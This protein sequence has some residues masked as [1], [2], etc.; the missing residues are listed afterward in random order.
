MQQRDFDTIYYLNVYP[1]A[2]KIDSNENASVYYDLLGKIMD[3]LNLPLKL[4]EFKDRSP[5]SLI[6][7]RAGAFEKV[8]FSGDL[9]IKATSAIVRP[10]G[11]DMITVRINGHDSK[12]DNVSE[13]IPINSSSVS[14]HANKGI[15]F[16]GGS[17]FYS[18]ISLDQPV[19]TFDGQPVRLMLKNS[20]GNQTSE[21]TASNVE[22]SL[23]KAD[24]LI[25]E[26]QIDSTGRTD[27]YKFAGYGELF[28]AIGGGGLGPNLVVTGKTSFQVDYSD[29][30]TI[31]N[32]L[33]MDGKIDRSDPFYGYDELGSLINL[34]SEYFVVFPIVGVIVYFLS[35]YKIIPSRE[36]T[37]FKL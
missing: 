19:I 2:Q 37:W 6:V 25:R 17:G 26:P 35:R 12:L 28:R 9:S 31:F 10:S 16:G 22:V 13:I 3:P 27:I 23:S 15:L 1:L 34:T 21:I 5:F 36:S 30:Y 33:A 29:K 8:G 11:T 24:V 20:F 32:D 14:I 18:R 7:N 4:Y